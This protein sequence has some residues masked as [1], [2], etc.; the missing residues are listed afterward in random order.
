MD[1]N[2][3]NSGINPSATVHDAISALSGMIAAHPDDSDLYY[4]R[5]RLHWRT[6]EHAAAITDYEHA[7]A[8]N[9]ESP[10]RQTL[11]IARSVM[12]FFNPDLLN[13]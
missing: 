3:K 13:P 2:Q 8:L 10:A 9:P 11:E 4:Q 1:D 5:G 6:G 7:V 12:D